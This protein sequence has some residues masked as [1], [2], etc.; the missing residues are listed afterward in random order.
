[1]KLYFQ[2]LVR[3]NQD[4]VYWGIIALCSVQFVLNQDWMF[5][6][7]LL[8]HKENGE[9]VSPRY[10]NR[11]SLSIRKLRQEICGSLPLLPLPELEKEEGFRMKKEVWKRGEWEMRESFFPHSHFLSV[12][13]FSF[14]ARVWGAEVGTSPGDHLAC[15]LRLQGGFVPAVIRTKESKQKAESRISKF[16]VFPP[17]TTIYLFTAHILQPFFINLKLSQTISY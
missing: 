13:L 4:L 2:T 1:M 16:R 11:A 5:M 7:P 12:P 9:H 10:V 14:L 15:N 6:F 8:A 3:T 17:T